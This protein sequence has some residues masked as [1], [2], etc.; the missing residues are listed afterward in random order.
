MGNGDLMGFNGFNGILS[1]WRKMVHTWV[2]HYKCWFQ[3]VINSA[4]HGLTMENNGMIHDIPNGNVM[5]Q[6]WFNGF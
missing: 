1:S 5:G 3:M 4:I 6:W 2:N